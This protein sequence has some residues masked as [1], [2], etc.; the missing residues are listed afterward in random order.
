MLL[1]D[2]SKII[3]ACAKQTFIRLC[4]YLYDALK[5]AKRKLKHSK[6]ILNTHIKYGEMRNEQKSTLKCNAHV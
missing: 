1:T 5:S 2:F 3:T 6:Q 4:L